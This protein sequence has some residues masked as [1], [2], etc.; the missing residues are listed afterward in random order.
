MLKAINDATQSKMRDFYQ[1][2]IALK[3]CFALKKEKTLLIELQ[4]DI[5]TISK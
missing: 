5:N 4:G 2:I 3:D 1:Y